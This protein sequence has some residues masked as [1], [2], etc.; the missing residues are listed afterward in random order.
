VTE[1][2]IEARDEKEKKE[3]KSTPPQC[4]TSEYAEGSISLSSI[5]IKQLH[6]C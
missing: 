5:S 2:K 4:G 6:D 3:R 1:G